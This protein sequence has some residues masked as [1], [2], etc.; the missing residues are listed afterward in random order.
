MGV[1]RNLPW[2]H[3]VLSIQGGVSVLD[4]GFGCSDLNFLGDVEV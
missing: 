1:Y 3:H 4:L 2:Q